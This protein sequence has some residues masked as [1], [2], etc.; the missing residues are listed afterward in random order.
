MFYNKTNEKW[1]KNELTF[2]LTID[3]IGPQSSSL[4]PSNVFISRIF[5]ILAERYNSLCLDLADEYK[6][7]QNTEQ[8]LMIQKGHDY[9]NV[10]GW[11]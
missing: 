11:M 8:Q 2:F 4:R 3:N 7:K 9:L 6:K 1:Q 5:E 10:S